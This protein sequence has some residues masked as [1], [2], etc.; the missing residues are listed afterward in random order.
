MNELLETNAIVSS[1]LE[2]SVSDLERARVIRDYKNIVMRGI[3]HGA[4]SIDPKIPTEVLQAKIDAVK[5]KKKQAKLKSQLSKTKQKLFKAR[6][7]K[8]DQNR[9]NEYEDDIEY[10]KKRRDQARKK[11]KML[12]AKKQ[13]SSDRIK[14]LKQQLK[15]LKSKE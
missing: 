11:V 10:L 7:K 15:D 5:A 8:Q 14:A 9:D 4:V 1:I 2:G 12:K 3:P 6:D 13:K